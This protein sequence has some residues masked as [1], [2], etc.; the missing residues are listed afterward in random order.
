MVK[1]LVC[2]TQLQ[3]SDFLRVPQE[4]ALETVS[5][6]LPLDIHVLIYKEWPVVKETVCHLLEKHTFPHFLVM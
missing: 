2:N 4:P 3:R 5:I 1:I 6:F